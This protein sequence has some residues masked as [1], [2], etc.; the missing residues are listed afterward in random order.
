MN[1]THLITIDF[2]FVIAYYLGSAFVIALEY[3][4]RLTGKHYC[5]P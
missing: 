4:P 2:S 1:N 3:Y 5:A